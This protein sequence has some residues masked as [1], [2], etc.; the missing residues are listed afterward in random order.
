MQRIPLTQNQVALVDDSDFDDLNRVKWFAVKSRNTYY[1][2]RKCLFGG[3]RHNM[4]MHRQITSTPCGLQT[5]HRNGN[6][7]DN[8][9]S[10]LRIC[11]HSENCQNRRC[12]PKKFS[13]CFK[14]VHWHKRDR[15]WYTKIRQNGKQV[16]LG[17][18]DSEIEAAKAYDRKAIELFGG[19]ACLNFDKKKVG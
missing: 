17:S 18:F 15:K 5:D 8:R 7:L 9:R 12:D 14:G 13:S 2:M 3:E 1:A 4:Q 10:N 19:F 11:T 6:G 16:H